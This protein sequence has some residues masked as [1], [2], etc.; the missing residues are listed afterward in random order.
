MRAIG[1]LSDDRH[2]S[3]EHGL[4]THERW[5]DLDHGIASVVEP[6]QEAQFVH[7]TGEF[8]LQ[9]PLR[10]V[11]VESLM[12]LTVLHEFDSPEEARAAHI[13]HERIATQLLQS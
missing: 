1:C 2:D 4:V 5:R 3:V 9:Q 6:A 8:R 10:L 7:V 12:R 13:T 11:I